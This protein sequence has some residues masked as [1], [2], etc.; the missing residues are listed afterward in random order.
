MGKG[1]ASRRKWRAATRCTTAAVAILAA[2]I[3]FSGAATGAPKVSS[4]LAAPT[5][6]FQVKSTGQGSGVTPLVTSN[7]PTGLAPATIGAVYNLHT[8]L[9]AP[10]STAGAG[11]VIAIID[12]YHDPD[13]LSDLNAFDVE[14][15]YPTMSV[16]SSSPPFTTSTGPCFYQADPQGTPVTNSGWILEESLD[17]EW[18]HAEAPGAT[19]VLVEA[20]TNSNANLYGAVTWANDNGATEESMSWYSAEASNESSFDSYFDATS[21]SSGA[22]ILYTAAA[23]D[24]GHAAAYPAASP[25]V[26]GVGGT[27]LNGCS[28]TS[29]AGFTSE[30]SWSDSGGGVSAYEKIPAYQSAYG[31][32]V[33]GQSS[34][35][36]SALTGGMRAI[37]DVSFDGNPNTGVSVYDSTAYNSQT[38]WFTLGGTSVGSPNWAGILAVGASSA[39]AL[40]G[41]QDIYSGGYKSYLKDITGGTN[42]TCGTDCTAGT[43]YDLVTGL[44]S[45]IHYPTPPTVTSSSAPQGNWVGTY[46]ASGYALA[47][48]NGS[49]D[50]TSLPGATLS[51]VQGNRYQWATSTTDVRALESPNQL[52]REAACWWSTSVLELQLSFSAAYSGNLELYALDY[53]T[54]SRQ[55][56]ISVSGASGTQTAGLTSFSNGAWMVFPISVASGGSVTI[57]V[58]Q[59]AGV[60]AVLSGIFLGGSGGIQAS[61]APQGNWVGTYGAS[62]YALAAWNG[63]SDLTS[64]PGATLSLVQGNRYQWATS[65]TD[66]RALES[67]NQLTREAACW[68]STSVL[69]LQLSFS[70]AYS[71]NLE[72]YALDYDTTSRQEAISVSGAS[73]TQTAGLTSFSNGAWMVFPISVASGGSVTIT[74]QQTAGVNAV[75]SGIFLGGSGGIQASSAPQGNWVGTYGASG[76]ALAAWN[77]SSDLTS[78]PG[79]TLSLVQGNRYQWAT[80]TTDVRALESPNQLTREAACWWSTSVLELQLSFSAAYSGNLEL[81]ALDYDTT[82]RQ[83]AISVSGASGTQTAGLTSFSN[84]AWMVFP[85]SVASGGSVTITVQQTA[86]VNAVLSGIFLG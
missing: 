75:L 15:G 3:G 9:V 54:T 51:L 80:S 8:G 79:A 29:C 41:S 55:E 38:G 59:T 12:A 21:T 46:G 33:Y 71:G 30:T 35:G 37:P 1:D 83:E 24:G 48:W 58:Q 28:G 31:G 78:L 57:T 77:G 47:A 69:E 17:I 70:A 74:V 53:D 5:P 45:P 76:Y 22:P 19:I 20:D 43:G 7:A 39:G 62:G 52:T 13:A 61:S 25:T 23:G 2:L 65:T 32:P 86:G 40:Q 42:G 34:G 63:S 50:L 14:Y 44:G 68:W 85:I 67:P 82:S 27:T 11:Q 81:Y 60:N 16:C 36:I 64:L 49:S 18:A 84:G 10:T 73:G 72:L 56:A 26:I 6:P 66:V 4:A